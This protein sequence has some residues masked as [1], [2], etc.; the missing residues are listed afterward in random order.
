[1]YDSVGVG[2]HRGCMG[3]PCSFSNLCCHTHRC[4][5]GYCDIIHGK[6]VPGPLLT[7]NR[8]N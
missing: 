3:R 1:M 5:N 8:K 2:V 4:S 7:S 6:W